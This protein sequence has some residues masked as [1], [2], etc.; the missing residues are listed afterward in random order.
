MTDIKKEILK[1]LS[2]VEDPELRISI[3]EL[4]LVY[5]VNVD[6]E[7]NAHITMTLT[8]IGCPLFP[9]IEL[10]IKKKLKDLGLNNIKTELIFDPPWSVEKMSEKARAILGM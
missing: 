2:G 9:L 1:R 10:D 8:T 3:V 5:K 7:K 6:K 4:G